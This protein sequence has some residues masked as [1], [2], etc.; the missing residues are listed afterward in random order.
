MRRFPSFACSMQV[1]RKG[2]AHS[3]RILQGV[4]S[5]GRD[6][7]GESGI[8][9]GPMLGTITCAIG[10]PIPADRACFWLSDSKYSTLSNPL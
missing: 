5:S 7:A 3:L 6:V 4:P 9:F 8:I 1:E 2:P 10:I